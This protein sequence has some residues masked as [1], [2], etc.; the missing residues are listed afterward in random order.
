MIFFM[1]L[2]NMETFIFDLDGT[3]ID[4]IYDLGDCLNFA[5]KKFDLKT[6]SYETLVTF[7][8]KGLKVFTTLALG[9]SNLDKFDEVY[10]TFYSRY[11]E[12]CAVKSVPFSGMKEVLNYAKSKPIRLI[13]YSNKPEDLAIRVTKF[14]FGDK[15]FDTIIGAESGI[16]A[17]P[18]TDRFFKVINKEE[19]DF[20]KTSYFGDTI[21]DLQTAANLGVKNIYSVLWGYQKEEVLKTY[22]IKANKYLKNVSEIYDI[23]DKR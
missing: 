18:K 1:N 5:L 14:C 20:N 9:E 23:I 16:Q 3:I 22:S 4:T 15:M 2:S 13:I 19:I 8:G 12:N 6:Y 21:V 10:E 11:K 7:L 17:K